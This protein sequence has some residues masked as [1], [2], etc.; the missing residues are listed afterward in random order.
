M[1]TVQNFDRSMIERFLRGRNLKYLVDS[2]GDFVVQFAY[3]QAI[4]CALTVHLMA[5]GPREWIY[6]VMV[7]SDKRIPKHDWGRAVM[8]CNTWNKEKRWPKS[9]LHVADPANDSV[10]MIRLEEQL[11]LEKGI[12]QELL[13]DFTHTVIVCANMFWEWMHKEQGM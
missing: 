6:Y 2:D 12:H 7:V 8:L 10:G 4:G 5:S 3:D 13:E 11:D 9:Y 1:S